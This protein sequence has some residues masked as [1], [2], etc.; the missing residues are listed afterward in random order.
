LVSLPADLRRRACATAYFLRLH[1]PAA[2]GAHEQDRLAGLD[3]PA[4]T[5]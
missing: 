1:P 3:V 2:P 5:G 4:G